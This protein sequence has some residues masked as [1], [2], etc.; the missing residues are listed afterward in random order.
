V[1]AL[2]G[3]YPRHRQERRYRPTAA[4]LY[5]PRQQRAYRRRDPHPF[6]Q[7]PRGHPLRARCRYQRHAYSS[8]WHAPNTDAID[9]IDSQNIRI[10]NNYIDCNDDHIA[11]K[12]E[13][14]DPRFPEGV[15]DNIYIA[16][17]T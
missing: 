13:K 6:T 17:N 14:A 15:V 2:A 12:A 5:H 7:L 4:D 9:P 16:N 1:G 10:T 11:I 3:K 8:P